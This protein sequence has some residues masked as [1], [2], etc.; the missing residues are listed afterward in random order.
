MKITAIKRPKKSSGIVHVYIDAERYPLATEVVLRAG[1]RVG[2]ELSDADLA[3]LQLA[4]LAWRCKET[5]LR[6]LSHGPRSEA[7]LRQRLLMRKFPSATVDPCMLE[8][9]RASLID[10][11]SFAL[12]YARDR[13]RRRPSG[14]GRILL[15][16]RSKGIDAEVGKKA[17]DHVFA[18][19]SVSEDDLA[20]RAAAKFRVKR[21]EDADRARRRLY[22]FL[23]R[24]GFSGEAISEVLSSLGPEDS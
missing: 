4:D 14:R 9:V 6:L 21:G 10:D 7:Q 3:A 23:S 24:R 22:G 2:A 1:L 8:L 16:L 11:E 5:A 20:R 12:A 17:V 18:E 15:E 13:I 19:T